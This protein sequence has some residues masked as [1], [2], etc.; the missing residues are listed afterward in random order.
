MIQHIK[1]LLKTHDCVIIPDFGGLIG[2]YEPA[3]RNMASGVMAPPMKRIAFNEMLKRNDGLLIHHLAMA[4][5][6]SFEE[7]TQQVNAFRQSILEQL[8]QHGSYLFSGIGKL[9]YDD[10]RKLQFYPILKENLLLDTFGLPLVVAQPVARLKVA[11]QD[12]S[13]TKEVIIT[14]QTTELTEETKESAEKLAGHGSWLFRSAAA[15]GL[16]FMLTTAVNSLMNKDIDYAILSLIPV[17]EVDL[18]GWS[19]TGTDAISWPEYTAGLYEHVMEIA[20]T[21]DLVEVISPAAT[22]ADIANKF[23]V[24]VG[25]FKDDRRMQREISNMT[26]KGFTTETIAGP[27]GFTRVGIVFDGDQQTK[28]A[29]LASIRSSV[30]PEAWIIGY[31]PAE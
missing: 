4:E 3:R 9:S 21:T 8:N 27:N 23:H 30:N 28:S 26:S 19:A 6:I 14:S 12:E 17:E 10:D 2:H 24:I 25:S 20:E 29:A 1:E 18:N 22:S 11:E 15:I 7:A 13:P 31:Q 16:L 5:S